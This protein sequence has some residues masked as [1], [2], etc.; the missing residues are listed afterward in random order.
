M[1][2]NVDDRRER[3]RNDAIHA[4]RHLRAV[5]ASVHSTDKDSMKGILLAAVSVLED[6]LETKRPVENESEPFEWKPQKKVA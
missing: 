5:L 4:L 6:E 2:T 1:R 3:R